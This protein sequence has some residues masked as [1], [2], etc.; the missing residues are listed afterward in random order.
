[1]SC[2]LYKDFTRGCVTEFKEVVNV[3]NFDFCD[4]E[5]GY[6]ICPFY[7]I[8]NKEVTIC[9]NTLFCRKRS[10]LENLNMETISEL[11]IKYCFSD[12][13]INCAIYRL[14]KEGKE[15]PDNL[16]ADGSMLK[17]DVKE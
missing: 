2:P 13:R 11:S 16:L 3:A 10:H 1:M 14:R 4:S 8:I 9:E 17:I 6:K 15:V 12:N 7:K 5:D